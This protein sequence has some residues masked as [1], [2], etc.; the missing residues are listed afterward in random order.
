M[1]LSPTGV[2][3]EMLKSAMFPLTWK[4][5]AKSDSPEKH[6]DIYTLYTQD[7]TKRLRETQLYTQDIKLNQISSSQEQ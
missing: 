5:G 6:K 4:Y 1:C 7:E 2:S 3:S